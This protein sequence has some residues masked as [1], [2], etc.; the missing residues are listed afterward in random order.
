MCCPIDDAEGASWKTCPAGDAALAAFVAAPPAILTL[1]FRL[2]RP[3]GATALEL[4]SP[5][6]PLPAFAPLL[7]HVPLAQS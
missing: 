1:A 5:G 3:S 6:R 7:E 4:E 2:T